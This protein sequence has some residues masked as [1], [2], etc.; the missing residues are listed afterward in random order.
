MSQIFL[1]ISTGGQVLLASSEYMPGVLLN[2]L[3]HTGENDPIQNVHSTSIEKSRIR[4][5]AQGLVFF[6]SALLLTPWNTRSLIWI[7]YVYDVCLYVA[8]E[9]EKIHAE[10]SRVF[11]S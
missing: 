10:E 2:I 11:S 7:F 3:R 1:I 8:R 6:C 9:R 5:R 4:G